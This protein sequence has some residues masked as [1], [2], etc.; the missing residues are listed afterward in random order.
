MKTHRAIF[1]LTKRSI[2]TFSGRYLA[3]FLILFLSTGFFAGLKITK[4]AMQRTCDDYLSRQKLY[5]IRILSSNFLLSS[6]V[7]AF[8]DIEGVATAEDGTGTDAMVE[9][10][11]VQ[12]AGSEA[13]PESRTSS[14]TAQRYALRIQSLQNTVNLPSLTAG[15]MPK[16][17]SECLA[18]RRLFSSSDIGKKL[19]VD[20]AK[21]DQAAGFLDTKSFTIV[22]LCDSPLWLSTSRGSTTIGAGKLDGFLFVPK[23][24]F[25]SVA[26]T[27]IDLTLDPEIPHTG[28]AYETSAEKVRDRVTSL[29][30][31]RSLHI[32]A[33]TREDHSGLIS[34]END[35]SIVSGIADLFPLFFALIAMLVC[36]TTMTRM[37]EEER[38]QI[39]TLKALGFSTAEISAKY[40][41]YAGSA[42]FLGWAVGYFAGT[43]LIPKVFWLALSSVYGFARI[44]YIFSL[45]LAGLTGAVSITGI[46]LCTWLS[47]R[48]ELSIRPAELIRPGVSKSGK[49][50]WLEHVT[51]LW[52]RLSFLH[53]ITLRNMLRYK[54]RLFMMLVGISCC[55]ALVLTGFGVKD[56]LIGITDLQY[57]TIQRYQI[58][59]SVQPSKT[60]SVTAR[61]SRTAA[62]SS[63]CPCSLARVSV[64]AHKS[65]MT[66]VKLYST[67]QP[68]SFLSFWTLKTA[69]QVCRFPL[70]GEVLVCTRV[71]QKL[72]L[73]AGDSLIIKNTAH[74]EIT[75]TVS[76]IFDNYIDNALILNA[77]TLKKQTEEWKPDTLL[78]RAPDAQM[79]AKDASSETAAASLAQQIAGIPGIRQVSLLSVSKETAD[80]ALSCVYYIVL[81]LILF[82]GALELIVIYNL[83]SINLAER[84]REIATVEVLGFY[85]KET[86]SYILRENLILSLAASFIGLPLGMLFHRAVMSR[87]LVDNMVFL[88]RIRPVSYVLAVLITNLFAYMVNL[89]MRKRIRAIP[90][91]ESLKAVE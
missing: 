77:D 29:A 44:E 82:S 74:Q 67:D 76:G 34:F 60:E 26:F 9:A 70:P 83:T 87:I 53:K 80:K 65:A 66:A 47:V 45:P 64:K 20:T 7:R 13:D 6:D 28:E 14:G 3:L 50:I 17:A 11:S 54:Q 32:Y 46:L 18:D 43:L 16:A 71:A 78:I 42:A 24:A 81:L 56:S 57:K 23:R 52:K 19:T 1:K 55:A 15:R 63:V 4:P 58:E 49:R 75:A 86:D 2:R 25:L 89:L 22:G 85:P 30:E 62:G 51:P 91:A 38:T 73:S 72:S 37:V 59:A 79:T 36:V 68:K 90:M 21:S 31:N 5:D 40:L 8:S 48:S 27:E 39:G 41:L 88:T 84:S 61:L 33:L 12:S 69:G 35:I 10:A